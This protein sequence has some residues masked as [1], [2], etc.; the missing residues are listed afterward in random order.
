[1]AQEFIYPTSY[2]TPTVTASTGSGSGGDGGSSSVALA[3]GVPEDFETKNL[4]VELTVTPTVEPNDKINLSL[5]PRVTEFEG[6]VSYGGPNIALTGTTVV[7]S[8]SGYFQPIFSVRTVETEV[9]VFDG[10]TVVLG[11]LTREEV[12][13]YKEKIPILGDIPVIGRLFRSEGETA[14][15]RNLLIFVTANL[16]SPG[17]SP[18]KQS[19]DGTQSNSLFQNPTLISPGGILSRDKAAT[20]VAE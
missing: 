9:T 19:L 5:Q 1:V 14:Q 15:K 10:A 20:A 16:I 17:G 8:P 2:G 12:K 3:S 18:A 6:Y 4:G 7:Q 13:E 11:G